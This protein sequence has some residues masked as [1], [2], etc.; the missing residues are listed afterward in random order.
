MSVGTRFEIRPPLSTGLQA[1]FGSKSCGIVVLPP[2]HPTPPNFS[3]SLVEAM[4]NMRPRTPF[5]M[6]IPITWALRY[7]LFTNAR[8]GFRGMERTACLP[9]RGSTCQPCHWGSGMI[10]RLLEGLAARQALQHSPDQDVMC[11][12][13]CCPTRGGAIMRAGT[14][15]GYV[16]TRGRLYW[17]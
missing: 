16:L 13:T 2:S 15:R 14:P 12:V 6:P 1:H 9:G 10:C 17:I 5:L 8:H 11:I 7:H 4:I 3:Q